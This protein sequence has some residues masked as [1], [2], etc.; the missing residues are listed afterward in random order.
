[1][2]TS[3]YARTLW[4]I[5][6]ISIALRVSLALSG[7]QDYWADEDT[8]NPGHILEALLAHDYGTVFS[9]LD[10]PDRPLFKVIG[11]IPAAIA[12]VQRSV[13]WMR[14]KL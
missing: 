9:R 8:A 13:L 2:P 4:A 12:G 10:R 6:L 14:T 7:G 11:V 1:M 3:P 5:L